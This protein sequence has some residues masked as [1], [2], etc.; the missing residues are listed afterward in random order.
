MRFD[1]N[2]KDV[3]I[4]EPIEERKPEPKK[5]P[6]FDDKFVEITRDTNIRTAPGSSNITG[7]ALKGYKL[8]YQGKTE[9]Y[10]GFDWYQVGREGEM[11]WVSG[12]HSKFWSGEG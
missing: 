6:K 2:Y 8:K 11:G 7:V 9:R 5:K 1:D 3:L 10:N 4:D 12:A